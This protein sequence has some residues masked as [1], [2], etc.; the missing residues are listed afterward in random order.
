MNLT[1][2]IDT[3]SLN[4]AIN[5]ARKLSYRTR[6]KAVVTAGVAVCQRAYELTPVATVGKIDLTLEP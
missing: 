6:E 1:C 2:T 4:D 5:E 3:S